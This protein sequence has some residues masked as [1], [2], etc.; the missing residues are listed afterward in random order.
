MA[1]PVLGFIRVIFLFVRWGAGWPQTEKSQPRE[2]GDHF[3]GERWLE[4]I[5]NEVTK[6]VKYSKL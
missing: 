6:M 1:P 4:M 2:R 5:G 3:L